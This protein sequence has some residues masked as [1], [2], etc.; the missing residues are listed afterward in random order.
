[1][2]REAGKEEGNTVQIIDSFSIQVTRTVVV[3]AP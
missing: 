1:M 2:G 3:L